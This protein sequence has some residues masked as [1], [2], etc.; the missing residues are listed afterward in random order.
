MA[1]LARRMAALTPPGTPLYSYDTYLAAPQ[2]YSGRNTIY[3]L[4]DQATARMLARIPYL[5]YANDVVPWSD[6]ILGRGAWLL[7]PANRAAALLAH[8][9][10]TRVVARNQAFVLLQ[11]P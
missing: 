10:G 2:F 9:P 3:A 8:V 7:A 6:D 1:P 4:S 5:R 11:G